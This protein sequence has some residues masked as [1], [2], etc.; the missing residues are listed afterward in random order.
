MSGNLVVALLLLLPIR[1]ALAQPK[2]TP[3]EGIPVTN[4]LVIDKCSACHKRDEKGNL[5][6]ISWERTTPEGWELAIKRMVRLNGLSLTPEEARQIVRYLSTYHGL[7]PEEAKPAMYQAERRIQDETPP[8]DFTKE[9]CMVCHTYGRVISWRRSKEEWDLLTKMHIGYF[10]VIETQGFRRPPQP[11]NAPPPP[12]GTDTRDNVE[13]AVEFLAKTFPL[14]TPEWAAWRAGMRAP[15]LAGRWL[16]SSTQIGRGRIY[17]EM[18]IEPTANP[19]EFT[20]NAKL[21]QVKNGTTSTRSGRAVLY[22]GY[23]WRGR[24]TSSDSDDAKQAREVMMVARDQSQIEG[25]WFW[26]GYDEFGVD[27]T[28]RRAGSDPVVFGV[29]RLALKTGS[30]GERIEIYGDNLPT[31]LAPTDLDLGSGVTIKRILNQSARSLSVEVDVAQDALVGK[32]DVAVRRAVATGAFALYDKID[33]IKVHPGD[34]MARLGGSGHPKGYQQFEAIAYNRGPDNK[35]NTADD[36]SL[37]PVDATWSME[38]FYAVY[39][40]D[41]KDFVGTLS[42][43]GLFTPAGEGPNPKRKFGRNNYGDV[44]VVATYQPKDAP[45]DAKPLTARGYLVVTIPLY[46]RWDQP[47]VAE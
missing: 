3:E 27:V 31:G 46:V 1:Q 42:P 19:D 18:V 37:G 32:R 15:K 22:A 25:R 12:P 21:V 16:V 35:P 40:D 36:V 24:S 39:G 28:L 41:D 17:G 7:A 13:R 6:R 47:E 11:P 2:E 10:P 38:E 20:T 8:N 33:Y 26:G 43:T 29:D 5:S 23:A 45:S 4:Q 14:H 30:T 34:A 9:A 44:W